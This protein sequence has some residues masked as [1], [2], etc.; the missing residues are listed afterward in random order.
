M[1]AIDILK[2]AFELSVKFV[3]QRTQQKRMLSFNPFSSTIVCCS[4]CERDKNLSQFVN[5][6]E[7]KQNL[8]ISLAALQGSIVEGRQIG[9]TYD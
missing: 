5:K 9:V 7:T 8:W 3:V 6:F 4:F 1:P 2:M